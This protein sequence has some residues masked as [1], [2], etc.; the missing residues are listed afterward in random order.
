MAQLKANYPSQEI[1][2]ATAKIWMAQWLTFA[3]EHGLDVLRR[4]LFL[5]MSKSKFL[6]QP[7]DV[8]KAI[9]EV[10]AKKIA[11]ERK[12]QPI[13]DCSA[14]DNQRHIVAER[15]VDGMRRTSARECDCLVAWRRAKQMRD[16][17]PAYDAKAAA[18]GA[19]A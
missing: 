7:A 3:S 17:Q 2:S 16:A 6:P 14:C 11:E 13:G 15:I 9:K 19:S 8:A 4:A 5:C 12:A 10:M 18:A 1:S